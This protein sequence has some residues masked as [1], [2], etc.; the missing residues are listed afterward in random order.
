MAP[1]IRPAGLVYLGSFINY[2]LYLLAPSPMG[3][4]IDLKRGSTFLPLMLSMYINRLGLF[5]HLY[6]TLLNCLVHVSR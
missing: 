5:S 6:G 2:L 1:K 3:Q 4:R